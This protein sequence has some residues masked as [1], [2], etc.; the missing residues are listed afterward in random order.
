[1]EMHVFFSGKLPS[2]AAIAR[3][4]KE[5]GF[6]LTLNPGGGPLEQ[7]KG[8]LPVRLR[9]EETGFEFDIFEG[10]SA[11]EELG[12]KKVARAFDRSA[13]LRWGGDEDAMAAAHCFAAALAKA[14]DGVVFD[15]EAGR[16]LTLG[17]AFDAAA[18][19]LKATR[20]MI[21][22]GTRPADIKRY[23]KP[24]LELR[25]DLALV[26]RR[27]VIRPVRHVLRGVL[28]QADDKYRFR[29]WRYIMPLYADNPQSTGHDDYI[30]GA[31]FATWQP[32]FQALLIDLLSQ[33]IFTPLGR[34][35]TLDD[36]V[37]HSQSDANNLLSSRDIV[38]EQITALVLGGERD[39][40]AE[41]AKKTGIPDFKAH[42]DRIVKDIGAT[43]AECHAREARTVKALQL[44]HIW[45]PS[46]F[47][48]ELAPAKRR[49]IAEPAFATSPWPVAPAWLWHQP[50]AKC[51]EIR[52]AKDW[53]RHGDEIRPLVALSREQAEERHRALET[54][55]LAVRLP[56]GALLTMRHRAA[57]DRLD[58]ERGQYTNQ[59]SS[60]TVAI[61]ESSKRI[62]ADATTIHQGSDV[63]E[64][65][66]IE[67]RKPAARRRLWSAHFD[68]RERKKNVQDWRSGRRVRSDAPMT[69]AER[70]LCAFPKPRFG[71]YAVF[72][73]RVQSL[74]RTAGL[75]R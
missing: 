46:P 58:P 2:K 23:L 28:L 20:H 24:L 55:V 52:F 22:L 42:F 66:S 50:P 73:D 63:V 30:R 40:A 75:A 19:V 39:R 65:A 37:A 11:V 29:V 53:L 61:R 41:Y 14:T 6:P 67:V 21:V 5:L 32:H 56:H 36:F 17:K 33:L 64:I 71:E 51:G 38:R 69:P 25:S 43:C 48:V 57:Q 9:G 12:G 27:L 1:M 18:K 60:Y 26:D 10:R 59:H 3:V 45:E 8:G 34:I 68:L 74:L 72:V 7:H 54:Y 15:A 31:A 4:I 16:L 49:K 35:T 13:N 70:K 47:P 44:E 62:I